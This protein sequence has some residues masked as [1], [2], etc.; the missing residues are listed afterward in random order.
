[1]A[2]ELQRLARASGLREHLQEEFVA[3]RGGRPVFAVKASARRSV[4]GIVHDVSDSGQTL[5][6]EPLAIVELGN[7]QAEAAGAEREEVARILRE[8][9]ASRRRARVG[10]D[11]ARR[12]GR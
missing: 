10:A 1:M 3:Q 9:S 5:F 7:R 11:R 4:P 12:G 8:L 6:V 2:E